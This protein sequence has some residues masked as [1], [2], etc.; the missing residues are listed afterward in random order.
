MTRRAAAELLLAAVLFGLGTALYLGPSIPSLRGHL[1][2]DLGDPRLNLYFVSWSAHAAERGFAGLW[3]P[4]FFHPTPGVLAYSDHLIGPGIA[5]RLAALAGVGPVTAF[6]L[7]FLASFVL[8]GTVTFAIFRR[9]GLGLWPAL[10]G[11][12]FVAFS[13]ARWDEVSHYQV[14]RAQW[15]PAVLYCFDRFLARPR[16]AS[17]A[18]FLGLYLLHVSGGTYLAYMIHLPMV[19]ILAVRL[20][21]RGWREF[22]GGGRAPWLVGVGAASLAALAPFVGGYLA[23][24]GSRTIGRQLWEVRSAGAL[25]S[26]F[27]TPSHDA[28]VRSLGLFGD[29]G[30]R[31]ALFPGFVLLAGCLALVF[32]SRS[33]A[34]GGN[35]GAWRRALVLASLGA[36]VAL[37]GLQLA[38]AFT[39]GQHEAHWL[40]ALGLRRYNGPRVVALSGLALLAIVLYRWPRSARGVGGTRDPFVTSLLASGAL[41]LWLS[42]PVGFTTL[43]RQLPG[44][45]G[46]RVSH[47]F[48]VFALLALA[49]LGARGLEAAG[50]R[51]PSRRL[52]LAFVVVLSAAAV[53]EAMPRRWEWVRVPERPQE[54]PAY[55]RHLAAAE[56]V[57]AYVS[58]PLLGDYRETERMHHQTLHWKPMVNG[59][60]ARFA[61]SYRSI[62]ELF[63]PL[64]DRA[65][66]ERLRAL[67]V[68]HLVV[69]LRRT[70]PGRR[71]FNRPLAL[72]AKAALRRGEL[73][74]ESSDDR[75]GVSVLRIVSDEVV[76]AEGGVEDGGAEASGGAGRSGA[77]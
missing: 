6:N 9:L 22:L 44:M 18:A 24:W 64:P 62:A 43:N 71:T 36:V 25:L 54:F 40:R 39:L 66:L 58:V 55:A 33:R 50:R 26:S 12:W 57:G 15:I 17:A 69:H 51:I 52:R 72:A 31:G 67:G 41:C 60:S 1:G 7:L 76:P 5:L 59:Y 61:S 19:A 34:A 27:Y 47:R 70:E 4:P 20:R 8:S 11:G 68:T 75:E 30:G 73:V 37:W 14:L 10:L 48:F 35:R 65:G 46:M 77:P 13:H 63:A 38:D 21:E 2:P 45:S 32:A 74:L 23:Q 3:S 42:L 28:L 53:V 29:Y 49:Y 56:G 16:A